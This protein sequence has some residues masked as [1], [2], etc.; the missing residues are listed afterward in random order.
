MKKA[1]DFQFSVPLQGQENKTHFFGFACALNVG[2]TE[3]NRIT[4][5]KDKMSSG[6]KLSITKSVYLFAPQ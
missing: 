5:I 6:P 2:R 4:Q 3:R 1:E